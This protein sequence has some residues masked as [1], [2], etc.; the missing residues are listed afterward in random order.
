MSSESRF[1]VTRIV[2]D[3]ARLGV[4]PD[5]LIMVHASLRAVGPVAG[6]ASGMIAALDEA[7]RPG[8]T[9]LMVLG[10]RN[11]WQ[12]VNTLPEE[13]RT[14]ALNGAE[15]FD[16][17]QTPSD[18][19]VG[20]LAEVL[21]GH[22]GTLVSDH[23]EGRFAARGRLANELLRDPPWDDY[24]GPRSPLERFVANGG[25]VL[26][27]G[28]DLD[29][30][31][32]LHYAEYLA[33][34]PQKR[35]VRRHRLLTTPGGPR[36]GVV[37]SLDDEHGIADYPGEDYFAAILREYLTS[38]RARS[39]LVGNARSELIDAADIVSFA[40]QWMVAHL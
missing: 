30:T 14:E 9:I 10:A 25:E 13:E 36:V 5:A 20:T 34:L 28:A 27:L 31:T 3:L 37:S 29:T 24:F 39:G 33:D 1:P 11:D 6:G 26:R 15:P 8:G 17:Q 21:R 23:P 12:W 32:V 35:R 16:Y 22:L 2:A 7:V 4:A 18:P 19:E 40:A 38:G